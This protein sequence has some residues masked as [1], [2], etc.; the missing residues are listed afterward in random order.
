[1]LGPVPFFLS[2]HARAGAPCHCRPPS[3]NAR[4]YDG[5]V[6]IRPRC[7]LASRRRL[8]RD[9]ASYAAPCCSPCTTLHSGTV[10]F[11][12]T[13]TVRADFPAGNLPPG[14]ASDARRVSR[15]GIDITDRDTAWQE[16]M[17]AFRLLDWNRVHRPADGLRD[18][19]GLLPETSVPS[20]T[21]KLRCSR[22]LIVGLRMKSDAGP[23][24]CRNALHRTD[25]VQQN[26]TIFLMA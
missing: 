24:A 4:Q 11:D 3:R 9:F 8:P 20:S 13:K 15:N 10:L 6:G 21:K 12:T 16:M 17:A 22:C 5:R 23:A 25:H 1:M 2:D 26:G 18:R 19:C 7:R 14:V